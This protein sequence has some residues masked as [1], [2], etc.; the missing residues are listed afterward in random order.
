MRSLIAIA[1]AASAVAAAARADEG[2][3]LPSQAGEIAAQMRAAGAK[4]DPAALANLQAAPMNAIVT[5][6]GC[7]ASFVSAQG[8]VVSNHHCVYGSIQYN[9]KPERDLLTNGFYAA[10]LG[11]E[12]PAAPGSRI[13]VIEDLRDVTAQMMAGIT[14]E[15]AGKA[16]FDALEKNQK[17][18]IAECEK[19]PSRRCDVRSYYGGSTYYMQQML[20]IQDVR[21]VYA[22]AGG[23][24]NYGG[25]VDN[26]QWPRHT[27]DFG[28]Y[29]A[30][31]APDGSA[32]PFAKENVPYKPKSFLKLAKKGIAEGDFVMLAGFPGL[33]ERLRTAAETKH[34][35]QEFYPLQQRLLS[36][37][38]EQIMSATAGDDATTIKY[39]NAV[40]GADNTK[41]K[42][43]GQLSGAEAISLVDKKTA[44][45]SAFRSWAASKPGMNQTVA[46]LDAVAAEAATARMNAVRYGLV[47]R[48]Q[49]LG[50][51]RTLYR[52]AKER[53][54]A[55]ADREPNFQDR[56]RRL[57]TER[58]TQIER[59]FDPRVDRRLFEAA[60]VQY[61]LL[62]VAE[63]NAALDTGLERIGLDRLY[64]DTKL[65]D[66]PT[67][68]G[69]LDKPAKEI[70]ASS[71]PF[72]K[73]AVAMYA[74]DIAKENRT[75]DRDGRLHA[76]RSAYI[77]A[78]REY[79]K[80][81]GKALYP[82]ANGTLR[83]TYGN[84]KGRT[85]DGVRWSAFTTP[86]GIVEKATGRDPF[87]A[88]QKQLAAIRAKDFGS[89]KNAALGTV[90]VNFLSTVDITGGNSGS[91]TL[92]ANGELVGLAFDGTLDGVISDW[93]FDPAINRTI[94]VDALYMR[95]VM[96]KVDGAKRLLDEMEVA[97]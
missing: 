27:G 43:L 40:R 91:A 63:R 82:D 19:Q 17:A 26:W 22:P 96:D 65:A 13:F 15:T 95:W 41:K 38:S 44:V 55:D 36:E 52:W 90:P 62:P 2:M 71:D 48:A 57:V 45:E 18:L 6:G 81:N 75:K 53:E 14:A 3:W 42:L 33:T 25:E 50:A 10:S 70:E 58:L 54:K 74:E 31:V 67:R 94:H 61:R 93:W 8:L 76:A 29:R 47:N 32:K 1:V 12:L 4:L 35:Y 64:A 39:A 77:A 60:L 16:R 20:E 73:L 80:A 88:T 83:L 34:Y 92:N 68:V 89:Y 37:Y 23:I 46:A 5:L 87:D 78:Y 85:R 28:F 59:R 86:Q 66:T 97:K 56:D 72:L 11:D 84:V 49:L 24:G 21:L 69:W 9:S 7:S 79:A 30:Y 51:A